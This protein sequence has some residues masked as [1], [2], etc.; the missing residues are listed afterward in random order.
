VIDEPDAANRRRAR[1]AVLDGARRKVERALVVTDAADALADAAT[2]V[3]QAAA[4]SPARDR[5]KLAA[6]D[7]ALSRYRA[8]QRRP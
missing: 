1:R 5:R 3:L 2:A 6:L 8:T 7:A 4:D